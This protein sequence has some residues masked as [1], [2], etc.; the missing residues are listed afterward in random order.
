MENFK[1]FK[2]HS[3]FFLLF[4]IVFSVLFLK[5]K[6]CFAYYLYDENF[7]SYSNG[8]AM[9]NN[10][11]Q[12][13]GSGVVQQTH[14]VS[15]LNGLYATS[16]DIVH[17][18]PNTLSS[19]TII[20]MQIYFTNTDVEQINLDGSASLVF[21]PNSST[22]DNF[23][24]L[25]SSCTSI[26]GHSGANKISLNTWYP[27]SVHNTAGSS[28]VIVYWNG[29][30]NYCVATNGVRATFS[31]MRINASSGF[32]GNYFIDNFNVTQEH[33]Q[34][35]DSVDFINPLNNGYYNLVDSYPSEYYFNWHIAF[36]LSTT[37]VANF[38][39]DRP[40]VTISFE[41]PGSFNPT[42]FEM[43]DFVIL[44]N[45]YYGTA[46]T[47]LINEDI[48]NYPSELGVYNAIATLW[49]VYTDGSGNK[50]YDHVLADKEINFTIQSATTTTPTAWCSN[51]C[52]DISTSTGLLDE[53]GNGVN[54][55][56]RS[57]ACYMFY[58]HQ[59]SINGILNQAAIIQTKFP[60]S[61]YFD[62]TNAI[63]SSTQSTTYQNYYFSIPFI[64][65]TSTSSE[66]YMIPVI[67]SSTLSYYIGQTNANSIRL[68][69]TTF[70]YSITAILIFLFLL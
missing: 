2:Q 54:C 1:I 36:N 65:K 5:E 29:T 25:N 4:I 41:K 60:A 39:S 44:D 24:L 49:D 68:G 70:L 52:A 19:S 57:A 46:T 42:I 59:F 15:P 14:Y 40:L 33:S 7:D 12:W 62:L 51:L 38:P 31:R 27:L 28:T 3:R 34:S 10:N 64:R 53:I 6:I 11:N 37:T 50:V 9:Y 20:S 67:S 18:T 21:Y 66:F 43:T 26:V 17:Y 45:E 47:T 63:A 69:L 56:L 16:T 48:T 61:T 55:A 22:F 30:T 8:S 23:Y 13:S 32:H 58:P 35:A